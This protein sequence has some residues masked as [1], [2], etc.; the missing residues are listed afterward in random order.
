MMNLLTMTIRYTILYFIS[1]V[2]IQTSYY[3]NRD[4][5]VENKNYD[6]VEF[7]SVTRYALIIGFVIVSSSL[8]LTLSI[9]YEP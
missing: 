6:V 4:N 2:I 1:L 8:L 5:F 7:M 3:A 9:L